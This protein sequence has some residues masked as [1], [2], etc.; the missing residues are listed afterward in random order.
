MHA[1]HMACRVTLSITTYHP[2]S[3]VE[4]PFK[5][6]PPLSEALTEQQHQ[7]EQDEQQRQ[8]NSVLLNE[9]ATSSRCSLC[10]QLRSLFMFVTMTGAAV[11]CQA[12]R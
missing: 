7:L 8:V 11:R 10:I 3:L 5:P 4:V 9:N 1:F 6:L 12:A 2:S